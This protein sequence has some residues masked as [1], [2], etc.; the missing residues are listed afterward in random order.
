MGKTTGDGNGEN[1]GGPDDGGG[2]GTDT[3]LWD[4]VIRSV[5]PLR[6]DQPLQG[7]VAIHTPPVKTARKAKR[8]T[9]INSGNTDDFS[10]L[11]KRPASSLTSPA[12]PIPSGG[13]DRRTEE[14]LRRGQMD[15]EAVLDLHG[16]SAARARPELI[17]FLTAG[18][19]QGLRCVLVITGKGRMARPT[20]DHD[21]EVNFQNPLPRPGILRQS[22][23]AWLRE[24]PLA[25]IV[26][27]HFPAK[28][29]HGGS[30]AFYILLRRIR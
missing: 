5:K 23:P 10:S 21:D 30:G 12:P 4:Y 7:P 25:H 11:L 3:G 17:R 18:Q 29:R 24:P 28:G 2:S 20:D 6:R 15:I 8:K 9:D 27:Q 19:T 22:L 14:R 13:L 1:N 26:L 16:L